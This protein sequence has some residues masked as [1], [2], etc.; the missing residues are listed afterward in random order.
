MK[1]EAQKKAQDKYRRSDKYNW[2]T[3]ASG[4]TK[5]EAE[6][7]REAAA[8]LETTP[9]KFMLN[10]ALYCIENDIDPRKE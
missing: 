8:K 2:T 3:I 6:K 1:T 10:A 4:M 5:S 7:I 9:S